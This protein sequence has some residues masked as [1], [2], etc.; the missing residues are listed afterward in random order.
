[1]KL[2]FQRKLKHCSREENRGMRKRNDGEKT[3]NRITNNDIALRLL[4]KENGTR[5]DEQNKKRKWES[6]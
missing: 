2:K 6:L 5:Y 3:T 1:M 4:D